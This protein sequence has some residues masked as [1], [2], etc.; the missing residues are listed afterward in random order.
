MRELPVEG[1]GGREGLGLSGFEHEDD[2]KPRRMNSELP[3]SNEESEHR[4]KN[5]FHQAN[6]KYLFE[7]SCQHHTHSEG[8]VQ[9]SSLSPSHRSLVHFNSKRGM[10]E[11]QGT[12]GWTPGLKTR[13]ETQPVDALLLKKLRDTGQKMSQV[14]IFLFN[15]A[16]FSLTLV[17]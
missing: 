9:P 12:S 4:R 15:T 7:P 1:D 13:N 14:N 6:R 5:H 3:C 2:S 8:Y 17:C 10:S 16:V 11:E